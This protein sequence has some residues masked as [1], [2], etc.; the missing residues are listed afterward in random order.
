MAR[1]YTQ[2]Q[3]PDHNQ[4]RIRLCLLAAFVSFLLYL[5]ACGQTSPPATPYVSQVALSKPENGITPTLLSV[6]LPLSSVP[7]MLLSSANPNVYLTVGSPLLATEGRPM[8]IWQVNI[9]NATTQLVYQ[10]PRHVSPTDKALIPSAVAEDI[11]GY[12]ERYTDPMYPNFATLLLN[13]KIGSLSLSPNKQYLCWKEVYDWCPGN[14]CFGASRIKVLHLDHGILEIDLPASWHI[15]SLTWAPDSQA[16]A[17]TERY[18][19]P[20]GS[21]EHKLKLL[22]VSSGKVTTVGS[23]TDPAWA[24]D[25]Q[26]LAVTNLFSHASSIEVISLRNHVSQTTVVSQVWTYVSSLTWSPDGSM[27]AFAGSTSRDG[28]RDGLPIYTVNLRTHEVVTLTESVDFHFF[29]SPRWSPNGKWIAANAKETYGIRWDHL[30]IVDS[31][32]GE[33]VAELPLRHNISDWEWSDD[34][35]SILLT[36]E[37]PQTEEGIGVFQVPGGDLFALPIPEALREGLRDRSLYL[38][39]ATW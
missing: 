16:I 3:Y 12:L 7:E 2:S 11:R 33:V 18:S 6:D 37:T 28:G 19:S 14:Y 21:V 30:V 32:S 38:S 15:S 8:Q 36:D 29:S 39:G 25:S 24:P 4:W 23:G 10:A 13:T 9:E 5:T 22:D 27:I 1:L 31:Q 17:F 35:R 26:R 20:D 34:C